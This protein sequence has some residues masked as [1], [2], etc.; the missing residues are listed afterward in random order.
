MA[1]SRS[2]LRLILLF[3]MDPVSKEK[4]SHE[5]FQGVLVDQGEHGR[6]YKRYSLFLALKSDLET[7]QMQPHPFL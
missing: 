3:P 1:D 2:P 7:H 5:H 6:K 4:K